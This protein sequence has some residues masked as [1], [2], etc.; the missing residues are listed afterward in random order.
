MKNRV[1]AQTSR[2]R[3]KMKMDSMEQ[4]IKELSEENEQLQKRNAFLEERLKELE[5]RLGVLG[6][7]SVITESGNVL[8]KVMALNL[9]A[10]C[11]IL[12]LL[13]TSKR[14]LMEFL[15]MT[16][17]IPS[18]KAQAPER[19]HIILNCLHRKTLLTI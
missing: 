15:L 3:K 1:A 10:I 5:S 14:S 11:T 17:K 7:A 12:S 8:E 18:R 2:D 13:F 16:L 6:S 9:L 4:K 19:F